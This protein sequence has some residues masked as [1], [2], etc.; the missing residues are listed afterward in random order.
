MCPGRHMAKQFVVILVSMMLHRFDLEL[1]GPQP[2]PLA[3][4]E[5]PSLGVVA[6]KGPDVMVCLKPRREI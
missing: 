1:D 6:S 3:Q 5:S 4:E 2:F